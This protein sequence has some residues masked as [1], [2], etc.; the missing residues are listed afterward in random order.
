M[1]KRRTFVKK[2]SGLT[3][4]L[5]VPAGSM[6]FGTNMDSDKWGT[7]LPKRR[8]GKTGADVTMLGV[9]GYH[10]GWTTEKDA[11]K[12]IE[13]AMEGGIRFLILRSRMDHIRAKSDME[14]TYLQNTVTRSLS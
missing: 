5:M 11:Q 13:A 2:L 3:A 10:I 7:V 14:S 4:G 9:G 1:E 6:A 12:V 8:L